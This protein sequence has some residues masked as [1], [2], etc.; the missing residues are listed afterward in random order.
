MTLRT[1]S[2]ALALAAA[3]LLPAGAAQ[4]APADGGADYVALG[5]SGAATTGAVN[6]D[7]SV[8]LLCLRSRTNTPHFVAERLGLRLDDRTCSSARLAHLTTSQYPGVA[9]QFDAL[10]PNT[11][12]VTVHIGANDAKFTNYMLGCH[13][14]ALRG[15]CA[16]TPD[17]WNADIDAIAAPYA[18]ALQQI[19]TLA[20]NATIVVDGWPQ[21]LRD[22]GCPELLGLAAGDARYIQSHFERLNSVVARAA[23]AQGAVYVDT[24][25]ASIGHDACAPEG[26]RWF[27]PLLATET[28]LPYH[29][30]VQGMRGVAAEIVTA[31][32]TA[33]VL[34]R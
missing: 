14:A 18:A 29:P 7:T 13:A 21:Y 28:L 1:I 23:T 2:A 30:T 25:T 3:A 5:D 11:R 4:A 19:S 20:P 10:G 22:G 15:G 12:L 31:V 32:R 8:P 16:G 6:L 33:G 9:P 27:D 24:R 26:V 34:A 17:N